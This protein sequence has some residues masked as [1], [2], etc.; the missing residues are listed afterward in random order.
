MFQILIALIFQVYDTVQK[1]IDLNDIFPEFE[2][3]H[4]NEHRDDH[5]C[6]LIRYII[7]ECIHI[8]CSFIAKQKTIAT[9]KRYIRNRLR[10][11]AHRI[12]Q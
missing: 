2:T 5:K 12:H 7:D 4:F 9:Q 6:F 1:N 10:K 8:K 3:I 11:A